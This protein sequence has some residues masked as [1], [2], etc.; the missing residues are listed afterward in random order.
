MTTNHN[1]GAYL[2]FANLQMASEAFLYR[3]LLGGETLTKVLTDGNKYN[4]KFTETGA[5][6]FASKFVVE[7]YFDNP[8]RTDGNN[9]G[10]SGK[11]SGFSGTLFRYIGQNDAV[12]GPQSA[13]NFLAAQGFGVTAQTLKPFSGLQ[14]G[15]V[16]LA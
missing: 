5:A 8:A 15:L 13:F 3:A 11:G 16:K 6:D 14:E 4:S 2:T 7:K 10:T 12:I 1:P 9:S